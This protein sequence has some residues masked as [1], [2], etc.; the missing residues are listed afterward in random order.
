MIST[1]LPDMFCSVAHLP[2]AACH[3]DEG[4]N[5]STYLL[6]LVIPTLGGIYGIEGSSL[7]P[8]DDKR[9]TR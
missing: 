4:G 6:P 9:K 5:Y 7:V 2:L 3:P 8:R 1:I